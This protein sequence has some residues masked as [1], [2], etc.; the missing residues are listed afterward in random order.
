LRCHRASDATPWPGA[1]GEE[2]GEQVARRARERM[3]EQQ[4]RAWLTLAGVLVLD[5]LVVTG[6]IYAA[7]LG[8]IVVSALGFTALILATA[9]ATQ[10][11]LIAR[12]RLRRFAER[13]QVLPRAVVH[14]R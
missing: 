4:T 5:V 13:H 10:K 11:V 3:L 8:F 7:I 9:R 12:E 6:A 14:R 2:L 1:H